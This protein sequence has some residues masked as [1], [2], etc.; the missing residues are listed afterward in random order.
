MSLIPPICRLFFDSSPSFLGRADSDE[1]SLDKRLVHYRTIEGTYFWK[2]VMMK[3][4]CMNIAMNVRQLGFGFGARLRQ[5]TK[6]T[7]H[8]CETFEDHESPRS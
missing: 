6:V 4:Y 7:A 1:E 2:D 3:R 5:R 8:D